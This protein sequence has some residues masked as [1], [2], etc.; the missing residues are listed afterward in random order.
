MKKE[1]KIEEKI[2]KHYQAETGEWLVEK[3]KLT[4]VRLLKEAVDEIEVLRTAKDRYQGMWETELRTK[5]AK[6]EERW[7]SLR[8][9]EFK[10]KQKE[11]TFEQRVGQLQNIL[12]GIDGLVKKDK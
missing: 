9:A 1:L 2:R 7:K 5:D 8:E 4:E 3:G 12:H 6:L 10:L 11:I